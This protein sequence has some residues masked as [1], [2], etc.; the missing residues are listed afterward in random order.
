MRMTPSILHG[1]IH[2]CAHKHVCALT[3]ANMPMHTHEKWEKKKKRKEMG[4]FR[5]GGVW[6]LMG[7]KLVVREMQ[8]K[9][10]DEGWKERTQEVSSCVR[11]DVYIRRDKRSP[12]GTLRIDLGFV[13]QS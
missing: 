2:T 1:Y 5:G 8:L 7:R 3:L 4:M 13:V 10:R 12:A 11:F 9:G 6:M